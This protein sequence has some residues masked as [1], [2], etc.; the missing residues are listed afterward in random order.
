MSTSTAG[1]Q[2][3]VFDL[4]RV[5]V[6]ICDDWQHACRCAGLDV[7][8]ASIL[9]NAPALKKLSDAHEVGAVSSAEFLG[10]IARVIGAS[11]DHVRRASE[12]YTR[13][14][15]PGAADLVQ[16]LRAAGVATACLTNTNEHHW[17]LLS[18]AGHPTFFPL[19]RLKYRFASHLLRCRK[20][21]DAIYECVERQTGLPPSSILFFD[22]VAENVAA[23]ARRGWRAH[24][25]DPKL[26][27][28]IPH[29]RSVLRQHGV[30]PV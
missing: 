14:G 12:A 17:G 2:L 19:D 5:L 3:V 22:D 10:E 25:V 4:G 21:D 27:N 13:G 15:Y 29:I 1:V 30:L 26:E 28:P 8:P 20:P 23:A 11:P 16:E 18:E 6:R 24:R 9:S 7:N